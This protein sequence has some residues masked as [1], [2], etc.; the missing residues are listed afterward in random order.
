MPF[1]THGKWRVLLATLLITAAVLPLEPVAAQTT[2]IMAI[3]DS[4]TESA[5]GHASYRY[6]LWRKLLGNGYDVNFVGSMTGV[7]NGSP[8]Y[9]NFDQNHEGHWGWRADE[10][11]AQIDTW[12]A[13]AEPDVAL[14]HL[15]TNDI[16]QNQGN[17]RTIYEIGKIIDTL[18]AT[19]PNVKVL[20][21]QIIPS[22]NKAAEIRSFN[23]LI[24]TL[25]RQKN[26][27]LSPVRVVNQWTGF[28]AVND[29]WDGVHPDE[30]GEKKIANKWYAAL[31]GSWLT[32]S[33]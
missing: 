8:R 12:A 23:S 15:G 30:S 32:P 4:I 18:R 26:T 9:S 25:A 21:A 2:K 10:I 3:G 16:F 31:V 5:G 27:S 19:N 20:L 14:I 29:T 6:W 33:N 24:P 1:R 7:H 11:L 17:R 28:N 22:T 13:S